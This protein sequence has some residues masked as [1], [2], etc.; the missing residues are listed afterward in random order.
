MKRLLLALSLGLGWCAVTAVCTPVSVVSAREGVKTVTPVHVDA[1][2]TYQVPETAIVA[3]TKA[4]KRGKNI[5]LGI[6]PF[7]KPKGLFSYTYVWIISPSVDD[8]FSWP[9]NTQGSFGS[10][11]TGDP[12]HF[13]ITLVANY[14]YVDGEGKNPV[15]KTVKCMSVVEINDPNPSPT[16]PNPTPGP[17][18]PDPTPDPSPDLPA[19]K[20]G[21][22]TFTYKAVKGNH[23]PAE[24]AKVMAGTLRALVSQIGAGAIT[25]KAQL[26]QKTAEQNRAALGA[27]LE[28]WIP[29]LDALASEM[30]KL[31]I[32]SLDDCKAAYQEVALGLEAIK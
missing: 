27:N 20:Y 15:L 8:W 5:V 26:V 21:L 10:G 18:P 7:D 25:S 1:D 30:N 17:N 22:T 13:E 14:L 9:D 4:V 28:R 32:A 11:V 31:K 23:F 24:E 12:T 29:F 16:P 3:P 6:K 19:G 2:D